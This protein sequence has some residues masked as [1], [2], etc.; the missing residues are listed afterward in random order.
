MEQFWGLLL[1][2]CFSTACWAQS[3]SFLK[4]FDHSAVKAGAVHESC[5]H[6]PC[7]V[8][9]VLEVKSIE[10]IGDAERVELVTI[11]GDRDRDS[12]KVEWHQ[13][14]ETLLYCSWDNPKY[15]FSENDAQELPFNDED[16][17]PGV[18]VDTGMLYLWVCHNAHDELEKASIKDIAKRYGYG[19][20]K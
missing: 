13:S 4:T 3:D 5:Y 19:P 16:F 8:T 18:L 9:K 17:F 2:A 15:G 11:E 1:A 20:L 12:K 14:H 7:T 10:P 6:Y